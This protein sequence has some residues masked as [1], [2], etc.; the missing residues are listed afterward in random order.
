MI[1]FATNY[2]SALSFIAQAAARVVAAN[3][4]KKQ[5]LI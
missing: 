3:K 1:S 4:S 2:A 5:S